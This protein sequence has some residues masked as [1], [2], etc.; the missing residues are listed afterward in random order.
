MRRQQIGTAAVLVVIVGCAS[1]FTTGRTQSFK[2]RYTGAI[3]EC[4]APEDTELSRQVSVAGAIDRRVDSVRVVS[5]SVTLSSQD[6][7]IRLQN[8]IPNYK[9]FQ[10]I[11]YRMCAAFGQGDLDEASWRAWRGEW[12]SRILQTLQDRPSP[13]RP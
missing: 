6:K 4:P 9:S 10:D 5:R 7:L 12:S 13:Q 8:V 1:N 2:N 11:D 3:T